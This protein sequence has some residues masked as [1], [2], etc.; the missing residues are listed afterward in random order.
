[1]LGKYDMSV[2][3]LLLR[4]SSTNDGL[5]TRLSIRLMKLWDKFRE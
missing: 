2:N 5:D 4:L 1:M 3:S